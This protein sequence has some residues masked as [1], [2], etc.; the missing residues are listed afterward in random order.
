MEKLATPM[1]ERGVETKLQA[2]EAA[3]QFHS[4]LV[5][6]IQREVS[7]MNQQVTEDTTPR[8]HPPMLCT[9]ENGRTW[10]MKYIIAVASIL[11]FHY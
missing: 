3:K 2:L 9:P 8:V 6:D 11:A 5:I 1:E 4:Q 7:A 10:I